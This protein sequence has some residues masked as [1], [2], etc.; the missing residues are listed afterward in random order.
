M[1]TRTMTASTLQQAKLLAAAA[2]FA[3]AMPTVLPLPTF[4]AKTH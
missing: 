1:N 4:K 2:A 3:R